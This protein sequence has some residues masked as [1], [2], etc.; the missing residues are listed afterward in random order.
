MCWSWKRE[1]LQCLW[2][3]NKLSTSFSQMWRSGGMTLAAG[4][5]PMHTRRVSVG[6]ST[7]INSSIFQIP[8]EELISAWGKN[9]SLKSFNPESL[10]PLYERHQNLLMLL[11]FRCSGGAFWD[12]KGGGTNKVGTLQKRS[13][14]ME[15][16]SA[17]IIAQ[18]A[19]QREPQSMA[20]SAL[21]EFAVNGGHFIRSRSRNS[22]WKG[23]MFCTP[24][25]TLLT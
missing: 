15:I 1:A 9:G 4:R 23:R 11:R 25:P 21:K 2:C 18:S 17:Q 8:P 20:N 6:G 22:W 16:A 3:S 14:A 13:E 12:A 19:V 5:P 24:K 10:H 7:E